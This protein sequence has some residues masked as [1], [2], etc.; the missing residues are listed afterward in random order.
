MAG[1]SRLK[2][3]VRLEKIAE[4]PAEERDAVTEVSETEIAGLVARAAS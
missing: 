3:Y 1:S 4:L 2:A